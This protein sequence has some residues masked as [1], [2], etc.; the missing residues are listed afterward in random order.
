M[1]A[2]ES[3]HLRMKQGS[4]YLRIRVSEKEGVPLKAPDDGSM[5][6]IIHEATMCE[7]EI[8]LYKKRELIFHEKTPAA[9][10]EWCL[11]E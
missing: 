7:G 11:N 3:T 6:R 9:S 4:Y 8:W 1:L 5:K 2:C 10:Y